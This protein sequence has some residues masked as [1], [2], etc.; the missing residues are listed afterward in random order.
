MPL[1]LG[2]GH[3]LNVKNSVSQIYKYLKRGPKAYLQDKT[4][5]YLKPFVRFP[6][7]S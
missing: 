1:R 5:L 3:F 2:L 6:K 7:E 4:K